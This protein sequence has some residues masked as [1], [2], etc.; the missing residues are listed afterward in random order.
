M[1]R[2][3]MKMKFQE[4][5]DR[6]KKLANGKYHT[7][8][9]SMSEHTNGKIETEVWLYVDKGICSN[10]VRNFD[11]AFAE[12]EEELGVAPNEE[13]PQEVAA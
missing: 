4:A 8:S 1:R 2:G 5:K 10:Y 6:L 13:I 11:I 9:F 12:I 7:I 3:K